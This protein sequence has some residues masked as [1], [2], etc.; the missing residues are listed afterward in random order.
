MVQRDKKSGDDG[1]IFSVT[2][3]YKSV[4]MSKTKIKIISK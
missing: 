2:G 3:H 1:Y 4:K